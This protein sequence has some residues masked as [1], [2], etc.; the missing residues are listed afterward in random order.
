MERGNVSQS[1]VVHI[2]HR[3]YLLTWTDKK[4]VCCEV[5]IFVLRGIQ[6][7][8]TMLAEKHF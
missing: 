1:T 6:L 2:L 5:N 8:R 7:T 4:P 3:V